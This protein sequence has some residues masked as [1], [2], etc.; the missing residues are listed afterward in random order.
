MKKLFWIVVLVFSFGFETIAPAES[1]RYSEGRKSV[2]QVGEGIQLAQRSKRRSKK[3]R[4]GRRSRN[5]KRVQEKKKAP[6][7][8][9]KRRRRV[10]MS[11]GSNNI[12]AELRSAL[13]MAKMG[14][15][16]E[17]SKKL[18]VLSRSPKFSKDRDRIKYLLG[19]MLFEM[20]LYQISAWEFVDI[21]R[22]GKGR[23]VQ[24][25]LEKLTLA[26][27]KLN[28]DTL[29]NYAIGKI[30]L[31]RFPANQ[32]DM[33]RYRV[34]EIQ[35]YKGQFARAARI[36]GQISEDSEWYSK[37][38]Y[39][40]GLAFVEQRKYNRALQT[41]G[42]LVE[43]RSD[44][45]VNDVNRVAGLMGLARVYY[46][47][48][49]W[50]SAIDTYRR[51]PKDSI[52]W[53]DVLF[54]LSWA[55]M[56]GVQFRNALSNFHSLHSPYYED[57]YIP[58]SMLLRAIVYLYICQY[59]E[60]EKTLKLFEKIYKP[61]DLGV[62]RFLKAYRNP[63]TY[64]NEMD[65]FEKQRKEGKASGDNKGQRYRIPS[66]VARKIATEGD[67]SRL[68]AH[69]T[70][71]KEEEKMYSE[72]SDDW[73]SS[74]FG[75][76][77]TKVLQSRLRRVQEK[78]GF[79]VRRHLRKIQLEMDGLFKQYRFAEY[80]M[81]DGKK[82]QIKKRIA[83]RGV[84]QGQVDADTRRSFYIQNGYEY[85]PFKGEY[86]LDEIGNYHYLGTQS[87]Q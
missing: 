39:L 14:N 56:R 24:R 22:R 42:R 35:S 15:R 76:Y 84:T 48:K 25:A 9:K 64:Y 80:E 50:Q 1:M 82:A 81:L 38:L 6:V 63:M 44:A 36:L 67:Y 21:I 18:F 41:F 75:R 10:R 49:D 12:G 27:D 83:G 57:Y 79:V 30:E 71:L 19:L 60:M 51:V 43:A 52:F 37:G 61:V 78:I 32:R 3:R 4:W 46:Q 28:D 54:E 85:W 17:A 70:V 55:Y 74:V 16:L 65:K 77:A 40:R 29:L 47:K 26:A 45:P 23:Y 62:T 31:S 5:Q 72:F 7:S 69:L 59:D 2:T 8:R 87:C 53:H 11:G 33:L 73:R 66:L 58:E 13:E 34:G 86:W 20:K 68:N